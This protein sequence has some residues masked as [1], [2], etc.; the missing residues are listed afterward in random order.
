[1]IKIKIRLSSW[2][3]AKIEVDH[4]G[5]LTLEKEVGEG[6]TIR[7]LLVGLVMTYPSLR[8]A[9]YNP[10]TGLINER[11]NVALNDH[12]L[13]SHE[14]LQAKLSDGDTVILLPSSWGG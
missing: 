12:L 10:D 5:W 11:I 8:E 6:S 7:D 13:T 1:M 2:I 14:V 3:A 4:S 9:V